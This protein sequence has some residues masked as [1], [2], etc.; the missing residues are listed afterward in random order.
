[1]PIYQYICPKCGKEIEIMQHIKDDAPI[2]EKCGIQL[3][4]IISRSSFILKGGG[5]SK[6]GYSRDKKPTKKRGK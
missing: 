4:K 6:H 5:W 1:M 2:C 3:N